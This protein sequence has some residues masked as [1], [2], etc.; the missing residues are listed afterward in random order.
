MSM[1]IDP[2]M[3]EK[4]S[5]RSGDPY[6]RLGEALSQN[7]KQQQQRTA[8]KDMTY[9]ERSLVAHAKMKVV[10]AVIVGIL[11]LAGLIWKIVH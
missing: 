10:S 5:G 8:A 2:R 3:Y 7:V 11:V 4:Y 6:K 1:A 9:Y